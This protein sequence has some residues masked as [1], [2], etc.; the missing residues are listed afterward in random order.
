MGMPQALRYS[1][2]TTSAVKILPPPPSAA[3]RISTKPAV[4]SSWTS[5]RGVPSMADDVLLSK[6]G[7]IERCVRRSNEEYTG[8]ESALETD[9]TRQD[10]IVLNL[11]RACEASIDRPRFD[12]VSVERPPSKC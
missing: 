10:A 12:T 11:Q 8:H 7:I 9:H 5:R 3:T 6:A 2:L 4:A 1:A